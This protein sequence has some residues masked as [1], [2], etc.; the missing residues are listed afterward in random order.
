MIRNYIKT[1][2]RHLFKNKLFSLIN[3]LGLAL[4]MACCFLIVLFLRHEFSYDRFH[5]KADRIYRVNYFAGFGN[6]N[7]LLGRIPPPISP[8]IPDYFPEV[9]KSA[10]MFGR[11]I[12]VSIKDQQGAALEKYEVENLYFSD[13]T[14]LDIFTFNFLEGDAR[15]ALDAPRSLILTKEMAVQFFGTNQAVGRTVHFLDEYPFEVTGV[16]EAFPATSHIEFNMLVPYDDMFNI[17]V[18]GVRESM[19]NNLNSNW[20]ISHSYTFVLLNEANN[21]TAVNDRFDDF[22]KLYG[23]EQVRDKQTFS[24]YP[25]QDIHLKSTAGL[26]PTPTANLRYLYIFLGIGFITL[27]IA[28]INFINFSTAGSLTRAKEVGLRK[29]L[30]AGKR[31]LITQFLG[32]S[33]LLSF[34]AFILSLGLVRLSLPF[35]SSLVNRQLSFSFTENWALL[36]TFLGIFLLAGIIAGS[37]PAFFVTRFKPVSVLKGKGYSNVPRGNILRKV[38]ITTQFVASIFLI[39]GTLGIYRQ[40]DFLR[41]QPMGFQTDYM[42][43]VPL[44]SPDLNSIFG[45]VDGNMRQ[46]MNSFEEALLSNPNVEA[47]TLSD[48]APGF[49]GIRRNVKTDEI[50]VE[51]NL[52]LAGMS[53]DY[54]FAETY[55]LEIVAGRDFDQ[56]FGTD[57]QNAYIINE[58]AVEILKLNSPEEA[59]GKALNRENKPGK[60][61]GVVQD[62]HSSSLRNEIDPFVM[63]V[64]A[65][66]FTN[67]SIRVNAANLP[68]TIEFIQSKWDDFFPQKT[69]EYTF[70]DEDISTMYAAEDQLAKIIGYF[71]LLAILISCFG[72]YGL[73][74]YSAVQKTKEIGVRKVLGA[75]IPNILGLLSKEFIALILVAGLVAIPLAYYGL[76]KWLE[77]Y[78][79]NVGL[80]WWLFVVPM[81][82]V[83]FIALIT[84]S[85]QTIRAALANPIEALRYE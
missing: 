70:L 15:T 8:N 3:V 36:I 16:V 78:P 75:S 24:L 29:V 19:R 20:V 10:R 21:A 26:E 79:I 66:V 2:L 71:A 81:L 68:K 76:S 37:Y 49:G 82:G 56:S 42:L 50:T 83:L 73:V 23:N 1:A 17:A 38:L 46:R 13:S 9:E 28:C 60:I 48:R 54:D 39:A 32:E 77:D 67:F 51:D 7:F 55:Q 43:N 4:G 63:D 47:I 80:G 65:A 14:I 69:F 33:L 34:A 45:G 44:F 41:N 84:L 31:T 12:S 11:N 57:H 85:Y 5:E 58:K 6:T 59:I 74:T 64:S 61:I 18:E 62:F 30:G 72:L 35:V 27:L 52:Y 53:V 22:I 25:I 40:L